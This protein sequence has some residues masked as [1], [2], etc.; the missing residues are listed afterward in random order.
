MVK[1]RKSYVTSYASDQWMSGNRCL[2]ITKYR[3]K[4]TLQVVAQTNTLTAQQHYISIR[5]SNKSPQI[6]K[7][8]VPKVTI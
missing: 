3:M 2:F 1:K 8:V 4:N 6:L 5:T 7:T